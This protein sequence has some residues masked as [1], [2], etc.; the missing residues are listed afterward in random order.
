MQNPVTLCDGGGIESDGG[1]MKQEEKQSQEEQNKQPPVKWKRWILL[2]LLLVIGPTQF[3]NH[4]GFCY[5]EMRYLSER[6][7]VDRYLFGKKADTMTLEEKVE[8]TQEQGGEYPNCCRLNGQF[9]KDYEGFIN[10]IFGNYVYEVEEHF[11]QIN[12]IEK[13]YPYEVVYSSMNACGENRGLDKFSTTDDEKNYKF[14]IK[15]IKQHW[16]GKRP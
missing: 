13:K 2:A 4:T 6:E 3:L 1:M 10:N 5:S 8:K 11:L 9:F 12:P 16:E 14:N 15:M 7:L